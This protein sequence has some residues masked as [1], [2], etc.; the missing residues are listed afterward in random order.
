MFGIQSFPIG[1]DLLGSAAAAGARVI[2][3]GRVRDLNE[4]H[5]VEAIEYE[6]YE[7]LASA[8][9]TRILAE[10]RDQFALIDLACVHRTGLLQLGDVAIRVEVLARHRKEGFAACEWIVDEVKR[11]VPIW[12]KE[13]YSDGATH[14]VG[15]GDA[16]DPSSAEAE[17]YRRQMRLPE[18]GEAGQ[19]KLKAA[20][21]WVVGAGGLGCPALT[22][23]AAAGVGHLTVVDSDVVEA[24]NL[25]RQPLYA[26]QDRGR[27]KAEVAAEKLRG[28]NPFLTVRALTERLTP[29]NVERLFERADLVIDG[30]DNFESKFLLS[31]AAMR[32]DVPVVTASLYQWEGQVQILRSGGPCLRCLWPEAPA[33]DCV[34]SCA[35]VGVL[36]SVAGVIGSVQ[37]QVALMELLGLPGNLASGEVVLIDLCSLETRRLRAARRSDCVACGSMPSAAFPPSLEVE[38]TADLSAY[39][40]IDIRELQEL[41]I[42]PYVGAASMPT[43]TFDPNALPEGPVLLVCQ[44]GVRSLRVTKWLRENGRQDV[45]SL[46]GGVALLTGED[47]V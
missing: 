4:G 27:K 39:R 10:A 23:L 1:H 12:K 29:E 42:Q 31:D 35:E 36:G 34:G 28:Q 8:E 9:G 44:H 14:W 3:D 15:A 24:S 33:A 7:P 2:F 40:Q 47:L 5:A 38:P 46:R 37:A 41:A 32:L 17:F 26:Y 11:R 43:S 21:V 20:R 25:H 13:R 22:Y 19:A 45:W 6:A 30:T 18:V 16:D